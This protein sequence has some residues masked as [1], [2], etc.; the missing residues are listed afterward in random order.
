MIVDGWNADR[1]EE[2]L[3]DTLGLESAEKSTMIYS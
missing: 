1:D 2:R 3:T